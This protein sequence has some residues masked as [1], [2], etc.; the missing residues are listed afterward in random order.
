MGVLYLAGNMQQAWLGIYGIYNCVDRASALA[1]AMHL[2][3]CILES[4]VG[5]S[6]ALKENVQVRKG[7]GRANL[8][9]QSQEDKKAG[10]QKGEAH[11]AKTEGMEQ[12]DWEGAAWWGGE[13]EGI[14]QRRAASV[15]ERDA[16][17]AL[18]TV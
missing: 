13:A 18:Q 16:T 1:G 6:K 12:G 17:E 9:E 14:G 5:G 7:E 10:F 15:A 4:W 11:P 3:V 8:Q 2:V